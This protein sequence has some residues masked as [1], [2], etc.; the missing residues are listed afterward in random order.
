MSASSSAR[1]AREVIV[2]A[3]NR[4]SRPP[5]G[6][7]RSARTSSGPEKAS[8]AFPVDVACIETGRPCRVTATI[9][10]ASASAT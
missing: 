5:C 10:P 3:V 2:V 4:C 8:S 6:S 7:F 9:A 1:A